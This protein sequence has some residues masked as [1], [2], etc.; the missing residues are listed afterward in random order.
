[1]YKT[2]AQRTLEQSLA[3]QRAEREQR[4]RDEAAQLEQQKESNAEARRA[5]LATLEQ[6][7]QAK[8]AEGEER[9]EMELA[10]EK[11]REQRRWLADHPGTTEGDFERAWKL[12]IRADVIERRNAPA[13]ERMR[14]RYAKLF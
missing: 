1:M 13:L 10:S 9:T 2:Q 14:E 4:E 7:R 8:I 11:A 6:Q 12:S 3:R 5:Y